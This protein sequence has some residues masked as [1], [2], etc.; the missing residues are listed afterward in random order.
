[1]SIK[2]GHP[3]PLGGPSSWPLIFSIAVLGLTRGAV[4]L[5]YYNSFYVLIFKSLLLGI[6]LINN[7]DSITNKLS[8]KN[9]ITNPNCMFF[10]GIVIFFIAFCIF[11]LV[12]LIIYFF[13][14]I[15]ND[16]TIIVYD[17]S[18]V[19]ITATIVVR[20]TISLVSLGFIEYPWYFKL[21]IFFSIGMSFIGI[22]MVFEIINFSVYEILVDSKINMGGHLQFCVFPPNPTPVNYGLAVNWQVFSHIK[23]IQEQTGI[24]LPHSVIYDLA[25]L[26]KSAAGNVNFGDLA[27]EDKWLCAKKACV[28]LN[29]NW[30][31]DNLIVIGNLIRK[32]EP[33]LPVSV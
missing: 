4:G 19:F 8:I 16:N 9:L 5:I 10:V 27:L 18:I 23:F 31:Y 21:L 3:Y 17:Y 25:P 12:T 32:M 6:I 7:F 2:I 14:S 11:R 15:I 28:I 24:Q 22:L 26:I 1:M 20:A 33:Y 30:E 29:E 13:P